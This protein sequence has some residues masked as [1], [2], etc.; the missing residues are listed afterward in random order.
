MN[1]TWLSWLSHISHIGLLLPQC[2]RNMSLNHLLNSSPVHVSTF[3]ECQV[4]RYSLHK[5]FVRMVTFKQQK[6]RQDPI[7][8]S[9]TPSGGLH[10][11]NYCRGSAVG[12]HVLPGF[13]WP[14]ACFSPCLD[15]L[16]KKTKIGYELNLH[17]VNRVEKWKYTARKSHHLWFRI[18]IGNY[19]IWKTGGSGELNMGHL[20]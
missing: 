16:N 15:R 20:P 14:F 19:F 5:V 1:D 12:T 8:C 11:S 10:D 17:R 7:I 2:S 3:T 18:E 6:W 4:A 9:D 13:Q